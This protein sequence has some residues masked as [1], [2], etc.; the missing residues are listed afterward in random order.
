MT[1]SYAPVLLVFLL[2]IRHAIIVS[3]N[4]FLFRRYVESPPENRSQNI[5]YDPAGIP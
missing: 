2:Q 3:V 4:L 1:I 5:S